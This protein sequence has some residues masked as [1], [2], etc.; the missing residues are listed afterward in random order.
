MQAIAL[1][2]PPFAWF[3]V[4]TSGSDQD[5]KGLS[6]SLGGGGGSG[7]DLCGCGED[8]EEEV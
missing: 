7:Q 8:L 5:V 3:Y 6:G 4:A 1:A 2:G